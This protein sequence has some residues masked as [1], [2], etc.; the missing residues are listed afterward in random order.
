M[1]I[2]MQSGEALVVTG[3]PGSDTV[4]FARGIARKYGRYA[5]IGLNA[6][7]SPALL[8]D[9]LRSS[10]ATVIVEGY[11]LTTAARAKVKQL[12][13][14]PQFTVHMKGAQPITVRAPHFIFCTGLQNYIPPDTERR[15]RVVTLQPRPH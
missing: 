6:L 7:L 4:G 14:T 11:P 13:T 3:E 10:P 15:F 5:V 1:D 9:I 2:N 12:I 8:R